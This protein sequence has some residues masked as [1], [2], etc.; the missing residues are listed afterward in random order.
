MV[1]VFCVWRLAR[2]LK[3]KT[4]NIKEKDLGVLG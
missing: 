4:W 2:E 3:E 1:E